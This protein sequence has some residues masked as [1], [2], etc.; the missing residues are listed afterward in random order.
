MPRKGG[1]DEAL[2]IHSFNGRVENRARVLPQNVEWI[3]Q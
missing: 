2:R 1:V 3:Y